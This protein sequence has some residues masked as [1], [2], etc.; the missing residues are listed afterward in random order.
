MDGRNLL[1]IQTDNYDKPF[2]INE[3][4]KL[5]LGSTAKLRVLTNYLQIVDKL[6]GQYSKLSKKELIE[7]RK[8]ATDPI[9]QW[10][11]YYLQTQ[12]NSTLAVMLDAAM[13]RKYSAN[14]G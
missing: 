11:L 3:G 4:T 13:D 8:K 10:A 9:T 6:H 2:S 12:S 5:D 1:R 7:A 14:P